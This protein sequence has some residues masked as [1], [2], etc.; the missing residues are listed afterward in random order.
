MSDRRE[1]SLNELLADPI[2]RQLMARDGATEQQVRSIALSARRRIAEQ[3]RQIVATEV[4]SGAS[5]FRPL[6]P[7]CD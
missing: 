3:R 7:C 6:Q 4:M 2:I 5:R 1:P